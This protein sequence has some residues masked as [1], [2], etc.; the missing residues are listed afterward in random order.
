MENSFILIC[1]KV[2]SGCQKNVH[3]N[4]DRPFLSM[5]AKSNVA[6]LRLDNLEP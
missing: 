1:L 6:A 2:G 5:C 3:P 4:W